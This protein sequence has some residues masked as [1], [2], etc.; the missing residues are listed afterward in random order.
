MATTM[1]AT[2]ATSIKGIPDIYKPNYNRLHWAVVKLQQN[3][4][5]FKWTTMTATAATAAT[6]VLR[7]YNEFLICTNPVI[8]YNGCNGYN[9]YNGLQWLQRQ[10]TSLASYSE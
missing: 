3:Y 4:N 2:A 6:A 10:R 8:D 9:G 7:D 1:A 5:R